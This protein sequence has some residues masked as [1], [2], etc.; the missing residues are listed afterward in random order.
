MRP[1][2]S[3]R[4]L[5]IG[6][7]LASCSPLKVI[8]TLVP[9]EG[10]TAETGIAYGPEKRQ[11]LDIYHPVRPDLSKPVIV[12]FYGGSWKNGE[13]GNYRFI[14]QSFAAEGFTVVVPD[15]RLYPEVRFPDFIQDGA[16]AIAWVADN[17]DRPT[18]GNSRIVL[19]GHSAG[20]HIAALLALDEHYLTRDGVSPDVIQGVVGLAGPYAFDPLRYRSTKPIFENAEDP[21]TARPVT[22]VRAGAPP[23]LLLHGLEDRTVWPLNSEDLAARL[24]EAGNQVSYLPLEGTGH[25]EILLAL[26]QPFTYLAPVRASIVS[27]IEEPER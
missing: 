22:F 16:A 21:D 23:T 26:A 7:I 18:G 24:A 17:L 19:I 13:R 12:F 4:I 1:L 9:N 14:G 5:L 10:Y 25:V 15:Y 27:F 2:R 6:F 3:C 11:M 20:A 8:D